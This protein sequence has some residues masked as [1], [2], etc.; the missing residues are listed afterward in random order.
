MNKFEINRLKKFCLL[1]DNMVNNLESPIN[2]HD[3]KNVLPHRE[4]FLLLDTIVFINLEQMIIKAT[5]Y[6][7]PT[8]PIFKG[9]F[10]G[11]PIYPGVLQFEILF[12]ACLALLYF[13]LNKSV[14]V[15]K[16]YSALNA[17]AVKATDINLIHP[18]KPGDTLA[19]LVKILEH[20]VFICSCVGQIFSA[21]K[22]CSLGKGEIYVQ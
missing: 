7:D 3:I 10:P 22:L 16:K 11:N 15:P 1:E 17:V 8:D 18:V 14:D 9:H 4:P 2:Q 6:I 12:Q 20:D 21:N 13:S 5:R 19:I